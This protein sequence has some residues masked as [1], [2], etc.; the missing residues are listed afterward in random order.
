MFLFSNFCDFFDSFLYCQSDSR[1]AVVGG[2]GRRCARFRVAPVSFQYGHSPCKFCTQIGRGLAALGG[3]GDRG[4]APL[5][6]RM[7]WSLSLSRR[8]R[9]RGWPWLLPFVV[10]TRPFC[11]EK[12]RA[13]QK[14]NENKRRG[15]SGNRS[16]SHGRRAA[17]RALKRSASLLLR[18]MWLV[19]S[20]ERAPP[21]DR[22]VV[23][24]NC[25]TVSCSF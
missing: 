3:A 17:P 23:Q 7:S 9:L 19:L 6:G 1:A 21:A 18:Y 13:A 8:L 4:R 22:L 16:H 14:T 12:P 25:K 5:H 2:T 10:S 20:R 11:T 15:P 24:N